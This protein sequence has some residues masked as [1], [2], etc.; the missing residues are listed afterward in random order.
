M[1]KT[2]LCSLILLFVI[3]I[4]LPQP[5]FAQAAEECNAGYSGSNWMILECSPGFATPHDWIKIYSRAGFDSSQPWQ[6]NL[7]YTNSI[8]LFQPASQYW[9]SLIIDFHQEAE[10]LVADF[11]DD[12]NGD[13]EVSYQLQGG[14]PAVTENAGHWSLRVIARDG[15]WT[16][17]GIVN[18]NLDLLV[19]SKMKANF[20]ED[21]RLYLAEDGTLKTDGT[22]DFEIHVRDTDRDGRPDYEWRQNRYPLP[23]DPRVMGIIRTEIIANTEDDELAPEDGVFWPYLSHKVGAYNKGYPGLPPIQVDWKIASIVQVAEFI[24]ARSEPGSYSIYSRERVQEG[25]TTTTDFETPF[26]FYDLANARDGFTDLNIRFG[27]LAPFANETDQKNSTPLNDIQYVWDQYHTQQ[28]DYQVGLAGR[29][30]IDEVIQFPEFSIHTVPYAKLPEWVTSQTWDVAT[31]VQVEETHYYN[32]EIV[33][34]WNTMINSDAV[35]RKYLAGTMDTPP[36]E[37]FS[38]PELRFTGR[39]RL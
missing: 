7:D 39:V 5:V 12:G 25:K 10:G 31:F 4:L 30:T 29:Q 1:K 19:D 34:G 26:A 16:K 33:W 6:S 37:D 17:G 21:M 35:R 11:Y 36:L 32:N 14:V 15:W 13:D 22:V 38:N 18:Y 28:W 2:V 24:R 8:W 27:V 23:E 3:A 9:T 20:V